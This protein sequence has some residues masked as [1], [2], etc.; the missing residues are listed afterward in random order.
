[1]PLGAYFFVTRVV[2]R[3]G[4]NCFKILGPFRAFSK[5]FGYFSS[6]P[7]L[8]V[9]IQNTNRRQID[10]SKV[11]PTCSQILASKF[12]TKTLGLNLVSKFVWTNYTQQNLALL[13]ICENQENSKTSKNLCQSR[14]WSVQVLLRTFVINLQFS[15]FSSLA[16]CVISILQLRPLRGCAPSGI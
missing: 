6:W 14:L 2:R 10:Q 16:V 7:I 3:G 11:D 4:S 15:V 9:G 13:S 12:K 1:M 5:R 8:S